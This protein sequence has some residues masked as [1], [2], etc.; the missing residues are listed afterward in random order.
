MNASV[1]ELVSFQEAQ[2]SSQVPRVVLS[3]LEG[4]YS[5]TFLPAKPVRAWNVQKQGF[6]RLQE[7]VES[8]VNETLLF[9]GT[10]RSGCSTCPIILCG[11]MGA[12]THSGEQFVVGKIIIC[13]CLTN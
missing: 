10:M 12:K 4:S 13:Y 11:K 2:G 6:I 1:Y 7:G 8:R 9:K 3:S 5:G